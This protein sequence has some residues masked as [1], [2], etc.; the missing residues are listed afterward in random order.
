ML[1]S[2]VDKSLVLAEPHGAALRYRL[3]ESIRAYASEKLS[4]SGERDL[5]ACRHLLYLRDRFAQMREI[6]ER[7]IRWTEYNDALATELEG[8]RVA[9]DWALERPE[10]VR[11]SELLAG[12]KGAWA[13]FG[14]Y[15]EGITRNE[16]FLA[17]LPGAETRLLA[18]LSITVVGLRNETGLFKDRA[19]EMATEAIAHARTSGDGPTLA[20]A[21]DV[22]A[23]ANIFLARPD[24]AETALDEAEA[25]PGLSAWRRVRFL[26]TRAL[27]C[28]ERGDFDSEARLLTQ[29][30]E[31]YR[32]RGNARLEQYAVAN[33][34]ACEYARGQTQRAIALLREILPAARHGAD[35]PLIGGLLTSLSV[36]LAAV[37]DL[38]GAAES[39]G[40]GIALLASSEPDHL[41]VTIALEQLALVHAL[42]GDLKRAATLEGYAAA[43]FQQQ[44]R[45]RISEE[46][47]TYKRL[48]ALLQE[49]LVSDE[50]LRLTAKGAAL[51]PEAAIA[52]AL[53]ER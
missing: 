47:M 27:L 2:L 14:L 48:I 22:Y 17:A 6:G 40:E 23:Y 24:D 42:R 52:T 9:L 45:E 49:G 29:L 51:K 20:D 10:V 1:A 12:I 44:G 25:I 26:A 46:E 16:Q 30:R 31:E 21:L 33:L 39:A 11:G 32:S 7:T 43:A 50:L 38:S 8:I 35:R 37:D 53:Q 28:D 41:E 13:V 34:A 18:R 36:Y 19:L 3:L 4:A 5:I 15:Q